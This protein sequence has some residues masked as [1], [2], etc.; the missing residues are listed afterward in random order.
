[1]LVHAEATSS[2]APAEEKSIGDVAKIAKVARLSAM[3]VALQETSLDETVKKS[4]GASLTAARDKL[5]A[6][7]ADALK[8]PEDAPKFYQ[9]AGQEWEFLEEK[10]QKA[11]T[12]TLDEQMKGRLFVLTGQCVQLSGIAEGD[13]VLELLAVSLKFTDAQKQEAKKILDDLAKK[14]GD[15]DDADDDNITPQ[16]IAAA[17]AA[18][19]AVLASRTKLRTL[20]TEAQRKKFDADI[21]GNV[22]TEPATTAPAK[23]VE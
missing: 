21:N 9:Q 15:P 17:A 7:V 20:M 8:H 23:A 4:V 3:L 22:N 18:A 1:L 12:K 14:L 11:R 10:I 5:R 6:V 13:P 16:Q 2:T 19:E